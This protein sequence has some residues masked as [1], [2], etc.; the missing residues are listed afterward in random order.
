MY[1]DLTGNRKNVAEMST[2]CN[3]CK[4]FFK[5]ACQSLS[6]VKPMKS[7]DLTAFKKVIDGNIFVYPRKIP[8]QMKTGA[9]MGNCQRPLR[10]ETAQGP[11]IALANSETVPADS[12]IEFDIL[13]LDKNLK[14]VIVEWLNYGDMRG[15]GQWRNS[16]KGIFSYEIIG[17]E[18]ERHGAWSETKEKRGRKNAKKV[19]AVEVHET[20]ALEA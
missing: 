4:G 15:L 6:R 13:L 17:E 16:G 12:V 20:P 9:V 1:S 11:R 10:A 2:S 5:D 7:Y 8:F 19:E 3:M 18:D 14:D